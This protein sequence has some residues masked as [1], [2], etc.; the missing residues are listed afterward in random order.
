[1]GVRFDAAKPYPELYQAPL[2]SIVIAA[3]LRALPAGR[4][5]SLFKEAAIPPGGGFGADYF[6]LGLNLL[7]FWLAAGLTFLLGRRLFDARTG[8]LAAGALLVSVGAWQQT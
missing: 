4:R 3:G 6:L 1:R 7:L 2:Y 8:T 5:Q